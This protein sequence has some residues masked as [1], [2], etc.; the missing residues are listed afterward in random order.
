RSRIRSTREFAGSSYY[1]VI[2]SVVRHIAV[3]H[4]EDG[5]CPLLPVAYARCLT[6][7]YADVLATTRYAIRN[8]REIY[9]C[10]RPSADEM[11]RLRTIT[12]LRR[13]RARSGII[14]KFT[15]TP[16]NKL[17][18]SFSNGLDGRVNTAKTIR[19][20]SLI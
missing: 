17:L 11:Q 4:F 20:P 15:I 9:G 8:I 16:C 18:V 5:Q 13:I 7:N 2:S 14:S 19:W 10:P 12:S 6:I 1:R 3:F